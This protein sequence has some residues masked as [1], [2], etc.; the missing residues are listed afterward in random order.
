MHQ[1]DRNTRKW[2]I[3]RPHVVRG[4]A[5][6]GAIALAAGLGVGAASGLSGASTHGVVTVANKVPSGTT[7]RIGDQLG[8]LES[9]LAAAGQSKSF[10][11]AVEYSNFVGGPSM[12]QAFGAGAIDVGWVADT[13]LIFAQAAHQGVVAV[14]AY[15]TRNASYQL[16][17]APG[18][19]IRQWKDL[20]GKKV[21]YQQGTSLEA[22]LLQGLHS[23][24]L[25][26]ADITSVN[27][28]ATQVV[29]AL[30]G[31]SVDA[32]I[33]SPVLDLSYLAS[34]PGA[35][36]IAG[37]NDITD[38]VSFLIA[39]SATL[40]NP[41]KVAALGN[42]IARLVHAYSWVNAHPTQWAQDFYVAQYKL[43]LSTAQQLLS[44]AGP[45]SF[46]SLPGS[47]SHSQ[48]ALANLYQAAGEIPSK[49]AV[50]A[51]FSGLFNATV[52]AAQTPKT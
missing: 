20:K 51:E 23:A 49:V 33:S 16:V 7:L 8:I 31:G 18:S 36:V 27:L 38:K 39:D 13:P 32:A 11:Y 29:A 30:E 42:Y 24:G 21:A 17:A 15:T 25:T 47:L 5:L 40:Q 12:L 6:G 37:P 41:A 10:P 2:R 52:K 50:G 26:L 1:V 44:Q 34:H 14:A 46:V 28:P 19:S 35:K 22:V 3:V 4:A 45:V 9:P 48:Q 43:P